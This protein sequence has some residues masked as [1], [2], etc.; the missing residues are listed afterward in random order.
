MA[1]Q[2]VTKI[3]KKLSPKVTGPWTIKSKP[4]NVNYEI[5]AEEGNKK[6][7][8]VHQN[9]LLPCYTPKLQNGK[10]RTRHTA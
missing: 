2:L 6:P 10:F 4:T 5:E 7:Q 3:D 8:V 9:R 1:R